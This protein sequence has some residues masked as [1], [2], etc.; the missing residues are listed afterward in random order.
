MTW[1][2]VHPWSSPCIQGFWCIWGHIEIS[3]IMEWEWGAEG[4]PKG[5]S[6][7][8]CLE[9]QEE[10]MGG[11]QGR[12]QQSSAELP[13]PIPHLLPVLVPR[14]GCPAHFLSAQ[15]RRR[16]EGALGTFQHSSQRSAFFP[17]SLLTT[18]SVFGFTEFF[19]SCFIWRPYRGKD[20]WFLDYTF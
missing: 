9:E 6:G 8:C 16:Q 7:C 14:G 2:H 11:G 1:A 12:H 15:P 3:A 17:G 20:F 10:K 18:T 13:S 5:K 19:H 4:S